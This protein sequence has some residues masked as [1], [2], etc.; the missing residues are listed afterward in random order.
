MSKTKNKTITA[1]YNCIVLADHDARLVREMLAKRLSDII[2]EMHHERGIAYAHIARVCEFPASYI[3]D[4]RSG[5]RLLTRQQAAR[6]VA[7][8]DGQTTI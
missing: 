6:L 3:S 5:R 2:D 8:A 1:L 4:L 7:L